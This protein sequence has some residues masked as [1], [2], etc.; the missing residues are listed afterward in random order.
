M[1]IE[2][3][4]ETVEFKALAR[5]LEDENNTPLEDIARQDDIDST[6]FMQ[7]V[8]ETYTRCVNAAMNFHADKSGELSHAGAAYEAGVELWVYF[9]FKTKYG[10][11]HSQGEEG[12]KQAENL[13]RNKLY[14]IDLL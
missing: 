8:S 7:L 13:K 2:L 10:V 11:H 4:P 1:I 5:W 12:L 6:K 3:K 14:N 9:Y